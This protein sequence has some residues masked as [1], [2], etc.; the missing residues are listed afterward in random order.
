VL[1]SRQRG[2]MV[3][4]PPKG[5]SPA[6][7]HLN[8]PARRNPSLGPVSSPVRGSIVE[9]RSASAPRNDV[10]RMLDFSTGDTGY[11]VESANNNRGSSAKARP[12]TGKLGKAP[13]ITPAKRPFEAAAEEEEE[14]DDLPDQVQG[15][16][17]A[18]H[19][20]LE[21]S[22]QVNG[23]DDDNMPVEEEA[24][25]EEEPLP[26]STK[27]SVK[28]AREEKVKAK[29]TKAIAAQQHIVKRGRGRPSKKELVVGEAE[30]AKPGRKK[31]TSDVSMAP[32]SEHTAASKAGAAPKAKAGRKRVKLAPIEEN[33]DSP[34]ISRA[35]TLPRNNGLA[36]L[37]RETPAAGNGNTFT[38]TKSGRTSYQPL[39][40]WRN[41]RA[42]YEDEEFDDGGRKFMTHKVREVVR[43][44]E[45]PP[46]ERGT[47][48][49]KYKSKTAK[50]QTIEPE[51]EPAEP[52]ELEPGKVYGDVVV[53][54]PEDPA[55]AHGEEREDEIALSYAAINTRPVADASFQFAKT[56]TLPF[57]GSGVV[58]LPPGSIKRQ[59]NSRKMQMAFFVFTGRV[60]ASV[61]GVEFR[62][63][64]GGMFQV[65]RGEQIAM[66][67][68]TFT[69]NQLGNTYSIE[70]D[71]EE[72]SRIFFS[73]GCE[74][75]Q[76]DPN[77]SQG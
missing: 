75:F 65:P 33:V 38:R 15:E 52:W 70:N 10:R 37:R 57:F 29:T 44:D 72:D 64:K 32:E 49:A 34:Q 76:D 55:G 22:Y 3:L 43:V 54:D 28:V 42:E 2:S 39:A 63:S 27:A 66:W 36:I 21:D 25:L 9:P 19:S 17:S 5:K 67:L 56:L 48:K 40:F 6:K 61:N 77:Q 68:P 4:P 12:G 13:V 51:E 74:V 30:V 1:A 69:D 18:I 31:R 16:D 35:P 62:I 71:Y 58:D 11:T 7:T 14:E 46:R 41:E 45:P 47:W 59:K 50:K 73:Q 20:A 60:K 26:A 24:G 53:W 23:F 8:S